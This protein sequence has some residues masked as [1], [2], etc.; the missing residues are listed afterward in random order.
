MYAH[1]A[2]VNVGTTGIRHS[3]VGECIRTEFPNIH[4]IK[5]MNLCN[6]YQVNFYASGHEHSTQLFCGTSKDSKHEFVSMLVGSMGKN[7]SLIC[8][9]QSNI[10]SEYNNNDTIGV[11]WQQLYAQ[12]TPGFGHVTVNREMVNVT[13]YS[14]NSTVLVNSEYKHGLISTDI[15]DNGRNV[16]SSCKY[17]TYS[18][19]GDAYPIDF[20]WTNFDGFNTYQSTYYM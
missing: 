2:F 17:V 12:L 3:T 10:E 14:F 19:Y 4:L 8:G 6:Q 20:C 9:N 7:D 5:L 18:E 16:S 1:H 15:Y 11:N 13:I